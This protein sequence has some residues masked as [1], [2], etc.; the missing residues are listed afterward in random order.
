MTGTPLITRFLRPWR[1]QHDDDDDDYP[2][3]HSSDII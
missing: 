1:A 2:Q 3:T